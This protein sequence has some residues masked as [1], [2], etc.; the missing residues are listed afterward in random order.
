MKKWILAAGIG[1]TVLASC[2]KDDENDTNAADQQFVAATSIS[3]NAEIM[4]GQLAATKATAPMVKTFGQHMVEE[5]TPAQADLKARASSVGISAP[6]SVDAEHRELMARLNSL[7]GYSFD[8]AYMNAQVKGHAKTIDV[9]NLEISNGR[10]T[11]IRSFATENL[12]HIQMHYVKADSIRR[13]L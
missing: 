11:G 10:N 5:H 2:D 8:T 4:A 6:D 1:L 9:F 12:P 7:S 13:A 3:N